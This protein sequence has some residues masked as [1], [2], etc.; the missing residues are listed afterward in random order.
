MA[1]T[2]VLRTCHSLP[3]GFL[4]LISVRGWVDP[5]AIVRLKGLGTM[6]KIQWPHPESNPRPSG[7]QSNALTN[8]AIV[9]VFTI[10]EANTNSFGNYMRGI[11]S[12]R[13]EFDFRH[14]L[15]SF[16]VTTYKPALRSSEEKANM[17]TLPR[18]NVAEAWSWPITSVYCQD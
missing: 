3:P 15:R 9:C 11:V 7:L 5:R 12:R 13:L 4:V 18:E 8:Y 16:I 14:W 1:V 6:K 2:S 17:G 10:H